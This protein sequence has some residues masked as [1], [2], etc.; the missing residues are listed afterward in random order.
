MTKR[1]VDDRGGAG[2]C[3][4]LPGEFASPPCYLGELDPAFAEPLAATQDNLRT[5]RR[6]QRK[7][8]R[9]RRG[10]LA[11]EERAHRDERIRRH[12][13]TLVS[14]DSACTGF[15]W[16]LPGEPDLIPLIRGLAASGSTTAIAVIVGK[17]QALE[18]WRWDESTAMKTGGVWNLPVP[19]QRTVVSPDIILVPCLGFDRQGHRL[20]NGG[21]YFDRTLA[22]LDPK[23][24]CIGFGYETGRLATI[25]PQPYDVP[26]DVVVTE[27]GL[28][29][30]SRVTSA[31]AP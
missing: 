3:D 29:V 14:L 30:D 19:A 13:G 4:D 28:V 18:F 1:G 8:L 27:R 15:C 23:P 16:P 26:M 20:G 10:A 12:L 17:D 5:W 9:A 24:L 22:P 11:D 6:L 7:R 31:A 25:Y 21:G 2:E